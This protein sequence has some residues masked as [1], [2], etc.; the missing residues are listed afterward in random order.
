LL[1][2]KYYQLFELRNS[3]PVAFLNHKLFNIQGVLCEEICEE[4]GIHNAWIFYFKFYGHRVRHHN[5][6]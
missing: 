6:M 1:F 4:R 2:R 5:N 3:P